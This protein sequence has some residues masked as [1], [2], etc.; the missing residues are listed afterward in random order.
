M[1]LDIR[2]VIMINTKLQDKLNK[3]QSESGNSEGSI[4]RSAIIKYFQDI[5]KNK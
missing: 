3:L 4:I 2:K 5:F 1:K